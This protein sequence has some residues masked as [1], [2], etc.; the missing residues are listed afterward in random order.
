[1]IYVPSRMPTVS[2]S[3]VEGSLL[4]LSMSILQID[5]ERLGEMQINS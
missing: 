4:P 3:E 5:K 1:M 2:Q